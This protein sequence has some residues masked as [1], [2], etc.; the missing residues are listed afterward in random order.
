MLWADSPTIWRGSQFESALLNRG[1]YGGIAHIAFRDQAIQNLDDHVANQLKL[2]DA[3]AARGSGRP[4]TDTGRDRG[5]M[6]DNL[7]HRNP[8][9]PCSVFGTIEE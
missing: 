1:F 6:E 4:E 2:S 8:T 5:D 7:A 9:R 3:E